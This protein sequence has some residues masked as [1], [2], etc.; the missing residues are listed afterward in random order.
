[1]RTSSRSSVARRKIVRRALR[2]PCQAA[3]LDGF[4]LLGERVLDVSPHG[5][6]LA[7]DAEARV[8][9]DVVVSFQIPGSDT[10][11][12]AEAKVA[13]VVGGWREGDPGYAVGLRFTNIALESRIR[14]GEEL[15]GTPPPVPQRRLR[16]LPPAA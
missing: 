14:L 11:V 3:L 1:M 8:G 16:Y 9:Q 6:L 12:D 10:W 13:R 4:E 2:T 15:R 5:M 7:A